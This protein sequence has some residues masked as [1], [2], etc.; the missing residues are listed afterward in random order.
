MIRRL[1]T[2]GALGAL[3]VLAACSDGGASSDDASAP[4]VE[5]AFLGETEAGRAAALYLTIVQ[6]GG[7]DR[8]VGVTTEVSD[9]VGVMPGDMAMDDPMTDRSVDV[10]VAAGSSVRFA[11][12]D[13]HLMVIDVS[14]GLVAG[15]DVEVTLEFERHGTVTVQAETLSLLDINERAADQREADESE[16]DG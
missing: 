8:L 11:P 13:D 14:R 4:V 16:G 5:D 12:G 10:V 1:A 2:V 9:V 15:D 7:D 3:A 6:E